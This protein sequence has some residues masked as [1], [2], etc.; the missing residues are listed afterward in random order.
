MVKKYN[1]NQIHLGPPDN[2][3]AGHVIY[4]DAR[5]D[6]S[7]V[8][9]KQSKHHNPRLA[10]FE[11][12]FGGLARRFLSADLTPESY[13]VTDNNDEV[14]GL[15]CE[16]IKTMI[17]RREQIEET[18]IIA[19][20]SGDVPYHFLSDHPPDY[21]HILIECD[22]AGT[23]HLDLESLVSVLGSA[24]T[25]EEDDLHKNNFGFYLVNRDN[26]QTVVFFKIDHDLMMADS[27]MSHVGSRMLNWS[28]SSDAFQITPRDLLAFPKLL[29]SQNYYWPTRKR[30]LNHKK[31]AY[32]SERSRQAFEHLGQDETFKALKWQMFFKHILITPPMIRQQLA[33][34]LDET[35]AGERAHI[36]LITQAVTARLAKLRAVLFS[37]PEFRQ[38]VEALKE[39]EIEALVGRITQ[40]SQEQAQ[41]QASIQD[42]Q[43]KCAAFKINDTPLHAAV[44]LEEYRYQETWQA[45]SYYARCKNQDG[46]TAQDLAS[47]PV[48][49]HLKE[50][51]G[52]KHQSYLDVLFKPYQAKLASTK[53]YDNLKTVLRDIGEIHH[54]GLKTQKELALKF[55]QSW[56]KAH[57]EDNHIL[58]ALQKDLKARHLPPELQYI[59]QLRS[60]LWIVRIF[61]G[62]FGQTSTLVKMNQMIHRALH[63]HNKHCPGFFKPA[64]PN[65]DEPSTTVVIY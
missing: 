41:I 15:V 7:P 13:L 39:P 49:E 24:Y 2:P 48:L 12:A 42:Y 35:S 57:P 60:Q 51:Q 20:Q 54:H 8:V 9:Y 36:T 55:V 28:L 29:D 38:Y 23:I 3:R 21:F 63:A 18:C 1:L 50:A 26:K 27:I 10:Q 34:C 22:R 14:S 30:F 53:T 59:S 43:I 62:L 52:Q 17:R 16:H 40:E 5:L 37:I 4:R 11:V 44:R 33:A 58:K 6:D 64:S 31:H 25:L 47:G 56:M 45:F 46:K 19:H 65:D 32:T 61:R